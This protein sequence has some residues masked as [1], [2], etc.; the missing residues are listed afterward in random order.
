MPPRARIRRPCVDPTPVCP[1]LARRQKRRAASSQPALLAAHRNP[2]TSS[3]RRPPIIA[4]APPSRTGRRAARPGPAR[5]GL[6][7]RTTGRL[8]P[9][10]RNH[11]RKLSPR[12]QNR[13][14]KHLP[15]SHT[16]HDLPDSSQY[17]YSSHPRSRMRAVGKPLTCN[18]SV[19]LRGFEPLT[20][21][22]RTRCATGLRYSPENVKQRSKPAALRVHCCLR[23]GDSRSPPRHHG[24]AASHD[25]TSRGGPR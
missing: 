11:V 15:G 13:D 17:G 14:V 1:G 5:R 3:L 21:S 24:H 22:M 25:T 18:F 2:T 10:Y 23:P 20:P 16:R 4:I 12:N 19:E 9:S 7:P 8:S 6:T